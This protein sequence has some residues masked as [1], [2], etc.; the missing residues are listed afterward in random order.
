MRRI[1]LLALVVVAATLAAARVHARPSQTQSVGILVV[2][3]QDDSPMEQ[4]G[5]KFSDHLAAL[6]AGEGISPRKLPICTYHLDVPAEREHCVQRLRINEK[7]LP[8]AAVVSLDADGGVLEVFWEAQFTKESLEDVSR[9][10]FR[11]ALHILGLRKVPWL[12]IQTGGLDDKTMKRLG[13][14][15]RDGLVVMQVVPGG[16]AEKAGLQV[17][18]VILEFDSRKFNM[19][20]EFAA[21]I[22]S[23]NVGDR[24]TMLVHSKG[25]KKTLAGK[26][27]AMP[28]RYRLVPAPAKP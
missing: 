19:P 11:R 20:S 15:T 24:V 1:S 4:L 14:T 25:S 3:R 12:G 22:A 26:V 17:D 18:D 28:D 13:L 23:L 16:A 10:M 21:Y 6:R 5:R 9:V 8:L 7:T 27:A 2:S